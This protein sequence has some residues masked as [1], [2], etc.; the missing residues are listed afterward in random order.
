M[1]SQLSQ[2]WMQFKPKYDR[3]PLRPNHAIAISWKEPSWTRR[4][5][6]FCW[7]HRG[8]FSGRASF[9]DVG[10]SASPL[11]RETFFFSIF[12]LVFLLQR[13]RSFSVGS[14]LRASTFNILPRPFPCPSLRHEKV[15]FGTIAENCSCPFSVLNDLTCSFLDLLTFT[16]RA[17][18]FF[19]NYRLIAV[20]AFEPPAFILAMIFVIRFKDGMNSLP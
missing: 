12:G 11:R 3:R 1:A 10:R 14:I 16:K 8:R 5:I 19:N 20:T 7:T 4:K 17:A 15:P 18:G 6:G 13:V 2:Q 9:A